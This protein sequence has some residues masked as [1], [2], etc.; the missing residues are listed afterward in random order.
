MQGERKRK[1]LLYLQ[2]SC[3]T[4]EIK[5]FCLFKTGHNIHIALAQS[6]H[7]VKTADTPPI[8]PHIVGFGNCKTDTYTFNGTL[9]QWWTV[10]NAISAVKTAESAYLPQAP[11]H[12]ILWYRGRQGKAQSVMN[13]RKCDFSCSS[14]FCLSSHA[15][16]PEVIKTQHYEFVL[17]FLLFPIPP[18]PPW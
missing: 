8:K 5:H 2:F 11:K 15:Q 4:P 7:T 9:M 18:N 1:Q 17:L 6:G 16:A 12:H 14:V 13:C 10:G 3:H